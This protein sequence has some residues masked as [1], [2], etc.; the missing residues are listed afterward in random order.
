MKKLTFLFVISAFMSNLS[1]LAN[2]AESVIIEDSCP[3]ESMMIEKPSKSFRGSQSYTRFDFDVKEAGDYYVSFWTL[4]SP[5][6]DGS[7]REYEVV[8][9]GNELPC[10]IVPSK[11]DWHSVT[12]D[13]LGAISFPKGINSIVIVGEVPDVPMVEHVK[14]SKTKLDPQVESRNYISYKEEIEDSQ[15]QQM[16]SLSSIGGNVDIGDSPIQIP[17]YNLY[18]YGSMINATVRYTF[19]NSKKFNEGDSIVVETNGN[20]GFRNV[21]NLFHEE[22]PETYS[23][24]SN[25][26]GG[27]ASI[28]VVAPKDGYY[29]ILV[30]SYKNDEIGSCS[31]TINGET[32][33]RMSVAGTRIIYTQGKDKEYNSF[34][35]GQSGDPILWVQELTRGKVMAFNDD[36]TGSSDFYWGY[37][38]R[39]K[40][41]FSKS[42]KSV[43]VALHTSYNPVGTCDIYVG[44]SQGQTD[45]G[46][47]S[48]LKAD[49]S[50][51]AA[52]RTSSSDC[53][54]HYNCFAWAGGLTVSWDPSMDSND[55]TEDTEKLTLDAFDRFYGTE[56]YPGSPI[57]TRDG[58]TED[59][60]VVDLWGTLR[61]SGSIAIDWYTHASVRKG[62]DANPHG[63]DWESKLGG[64]QRIFHPRYALTGSTYGKVVHHYRLQNTSAD[65]NTLEESIADGLAVMASID[66]TD[67]EKTVVNEEIAN[68][69]PLVLSEFENLYGAWQE[70][71]DNSVYSLSVQIADC[72]EY[73][74]LLRFCQEK[75]MLYP[76]LAV[77]MDGSHSAMKL[78]YDLTSNSQ[79]E[80]YK[81]IRQENEKNRYNEDGAMIIRS[82]PTEFT[83]YVKRLISSDFGR[84]VNTDD[85][86]ES[87]SNS[88]DITVATSN[89]DI[90]T[91]VNLD[92]PSMVSA[93][94]LDKEGNVVSSLLKSITLDCGRHTLS[95]TMLKPGIYFVKVIVN[96]RWNVKKVIL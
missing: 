47:F 78:I 30:H 7:F 73:R 41:T 23:W 74:N 72:D 58:A 19:H 20:N 89:H 32:L 38:P 1:L 46:D 21:L 56:R 63:Y 15:L 17:Y 92:S 13:D 70:V 5:N 66:F 86:A 2:S 22:Y 24:C 31:V 25:S 65:Y 84:D 59:N 10:K 87:Y 6:R 4:P 55:D 44:C 45:G 88:D 67:E 43:L 42:A 62:G 9:N 64:A 12:L 48:R 36:Y 81:A 40:K 37:N 54:V 61:D 39:V 60:S 95:S 94:I 49:D 85:Y 77:F 90:K 69:S 80:I 75:Q 50:M 27:K 96:G 18:N 53:P 35:I 52:E 51:M 82:T 28:K 3:A 16:S 68:Y 14:L 79:R 29:Q 91:D 8:V 76:A 33:N 11:N 26:S 71:W 57:Y 34:A 83:A 93:E